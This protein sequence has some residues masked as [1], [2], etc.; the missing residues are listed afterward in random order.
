MDTEGAA[1][2]LARLAG[3]SG[4]IYGGD[5]NPDQWPEET[6]RDDARLMRE[7]GVN[8]VTLPVFS[9]PRLEPEPGRFDFSWLDRVLDLLW[10]HGIH[11]DLATGTATPPAW[12]VRRHPEVLPVNADGVRLE[13][14]SRQAYC[15]SSPVFRSYATRLTEAMARRYGGHDAVALWH[16][17]NEYGDHVARCYCPATAAHFRDWL[18][19][20]F[21]DVDRLNDAWGTSCWG[22]TY[23]DWEQIEPPRITT[24]P[25]NPAQRLDFERFSS[26]ALL[27]LFRAEV[28]VLR[29]VTPDLP[30]T[31]NFMS[32]FRELDYWR[33]AEIEDV[34]T[35]DA[36]P[37]PADPTSHISAALNYG[38]MRALKNGQPWL[39]LEQAPS[40]VSWRDV[41]APKPPGRMR[42]DSLQAVAHG[43]DGVMFFQWRAARFG[44]EKF[45]SA[46]LGHR[47]TASRSYQE[48]HDLGAELQSLA[49]IKGSRVEA[50][51]ALVVDWDAWWGMD[52]PDSMPSQWL[53]WLS[54]VSDWHRVLYSLGLTV[55]PVQATG[56]FD[57]YDMVVVPNLYL[58]D[59]VQADALD[60]FVRNGGRL[61]VGPFSGVVD[62]EDKVHP[63]GAPGPLRRLLGVEIDE[64]WPLPDGAETSVRLDG[65]AY[66][67]TRWAEWLEVTDADVTA[68]YDTGPLRGRPAI[69]RRPEG[70]GAACYVS[71]GLDDAGL[72]AVLDAECRAVG[73]A[74][75]EQPGVGLEMT[76]RRHDHLRWTFVL[77]HG[78]EAVKAVVPPGVDLLTTGAVGGAV[79]VPAGGALVVRH[80]TPPGE[81]PTKPN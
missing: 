15:P 41:N 65:E 8:L 14:G 24:G 70:D 51:V 2:R 31:T 27:E 77:N 78:D 62:R 17:S 79:N 9:W 40:A 11:V 21:A 19:R 55:D 66:S 3:I 37:D 23:T 12:L 57:A 20:R 33:F 42:L 53:R 35:D 67:V 63:G 30:V 48:C 68:W 4:L 60:R 45:H 6:W 74:V 58:A 47:G 25:I 29:E 13:F 52:A 32:L 61:V 34:V 43:S 10:D 76:T 64:W 56:P 39:L 72:R 73:L 49:E 54:Q 7:A 50:R 69:T 80:E 28:N 81:S 5:Y 18:R 36:Y 44:P 22:Q 75:R 38:L 71:A 59:D 26:D 46:M 16:V 1:D